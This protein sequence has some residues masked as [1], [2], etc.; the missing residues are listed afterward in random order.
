MAN[1]NQISLKDGRLVLKGDEGGSPWETAYNTNQSFGLSGIEQ[2]NGGLLAYGDR[3]ST[4]KRQEKFYS[5]FNLNDQNSITNLL[6]QNFR[7]TEPS[8]IKDPYQDLTGGSDAIDAQKD[9]LGAD[10]KALTASIT[11]T[12]V[13]GVTI[14]PESTLADLQKMAQGIGAT[15]SAEEK[16]IKEAGLAEGAKYDP[17]I[18]KAKSDKGKGLGISEVSAGEAGGFMNTQFAGMAAEAGLSPEKARLMGRYG[19]GGELMR[20]KSEYDTNISNLE[21]QKQAAIAQ[22]ENAMRTFIATGKQS[23]FD[24]AYKMFQAAQQAADAKQKAANDMA[25]NV[26]DQME[27]VLNVDKYN[28]DVQK[29]LSGEERADYKEYLDG[30]KLDVDIAALTGEWN[31]AKTVAE[32]KR[33]SDEAFQQLGYELNEKQFEEMVRNNT[34]NNKLAS[35]RLDWE[36]SKEE[37]ANKNVDINQAV[38]DALNGL[39]G[40]EKGQPGYQAYKQKLNNVR[41]L[42]KEEAQNTGNAYYD[43]KGSAGASGGGLTSSQSDVL[44]KV[45]A[46]YPQLNDLKAIFEQ[47]KASGKTGA[48]IGKIKKLDFTDPEVAQFKA[49]LAGIIPTVARGVYGEVGVLTDNDMNNYARAVAKIDN[50]NEAADAIFTNMLKTLET[51]VTSYLKVAANNQKDV[52]GFANDYA[53]LVSSIRSVTGQKMPVAS[54]NPA[55]YNSLDEFASSIGGQ[56][57]FTWMTTAANDMKQAGIEDPEDYFQFLKEAAVNKN[58]FKD[59]DFEQSDSGGGAI[60]PSFNNVG[61]DTNKGIGTLSEKYESGGDPGVIGYDSTGGYSYGA[62]QLAHQNAKKFVEQSPYAKEFQ[63]LTF[64]SPEWQAKWKEIAKE[65]PEGFGQSQKSYISNT[66]YAPQLSKI[67]NSGIDINK[68]SPVLQDVIWSTA[69][70]HGPNTDVIVKAYNDAKKI[71]KREPS[72]DELITQIYNERATRFPSSTPEIRA[73]VQKRFAKERDQALKMLA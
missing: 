50:P 32:K 57:Y 13:S 66:H 9:K 36:K 70:Q 34:F 20:I 17:L 59:V 23:A 48:I 63:S 42:Y 41:T 26:Q 73:S 16:R 11:D 33:I 38:Q 10:Y 7:T 40:I 5:N 55:V 4:G 53:D 8:I 44:S 45:F 47:M 12:P 31:G 19:S 61:A 71:L 62:Y 49:Q 2:V 14:T 15:D 28:L 72:D 65:D 3:D 29:Y 46:V 43:I 60:Q 54:T 18:S 56:K 22:A 51:K 25:K 64:N 58:L 67:V 30:K 39:G 6:A 27:Y 35:A 68:F 24:N 21:T 52:S 1:Y 37:A 69:V